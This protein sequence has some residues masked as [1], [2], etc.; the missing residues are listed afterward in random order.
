MEMHRHMQKKSLLATDSGF[1][2]RIKRPSIIVIARAKV[3]IKESRFIVLRD[4]N[5]TPVFKFLIQSIF[6]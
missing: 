2:R 6:F 5:E 4:F 3:A 1:L